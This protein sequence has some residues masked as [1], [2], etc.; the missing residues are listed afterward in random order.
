[1]TEVTEK[2]KYLFISAKIQETIWKIHYISNPKPEPCDQDGSSGETGL[3]AAGIRV[4]Y[5]D[6][7][8]SRFHRP[9]ALRNDVQ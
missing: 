5:N 3:I 2:W 6:I 1:M 7:P 9:H 4:E 8:S